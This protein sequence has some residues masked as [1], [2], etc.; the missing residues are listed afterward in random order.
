MQNLQCQISTQQG[1]NL[2]FPTFLKIKESVKNTYFVPFDIY[3]YATKSDYQMKS[4]QP[5]D[6]ITHESYYDM[7]GRSLDSIYLVRPDDFS[8]RR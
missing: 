2:H 7:K 5:F 8:F 4:P 3:G 1:A 6:I